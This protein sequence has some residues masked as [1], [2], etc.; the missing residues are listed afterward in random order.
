MDVEVGGWIR[1]EGKRMDGLMW[2]W[3]DTEMKE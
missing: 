3:V 1:D 2:R